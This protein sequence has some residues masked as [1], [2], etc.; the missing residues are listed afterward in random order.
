MKDLDI[1]WQTDRE[2]E[3]VKND[4][5][6]EVTFMMVTAVINASLSGAFVKKKKRTG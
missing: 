2:L 6:G 1:H 3:R 5:K 4:S